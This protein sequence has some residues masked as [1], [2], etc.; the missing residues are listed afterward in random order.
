MLKISV[1]YCGLEGPDAAV[2]GDRTFKA[3]DPQAPPRSLAEC[4]PAVV[5]S[6]TRKCNLNCE[7]CHRDTGLPPGHGELE[8]DQAKAVLDDLAAF[9]VPIVEFCGGEPM[10]RH[11]LFELLQYANQLGLKTILSTNGTLI[12]S[13][14]AAGFDQSNVSRVGVSLVS[15]DPQVNDRMRGESGTFDR[16]IKG[17]R[18]CKAAGQYVGF[19][20][21]LWPELIEHLDAAFELIEAEQVDRACFYHPC[22]ADQEAVKQMPRRSQ[23]RD[24]VDRIIEFTGRAA[25]AGR[26]VEMVTEDGAFDGPYL[27]V[28]MRRENHPD[29]SQVRQM[30]EWDGGARFL[31]GVGVAHI[32][33]VGH[34]HPDRHATYRSLGSVKR[35]KFSEIWQDQTNPDLAG[36]R[37]RLPRLTGRCARCRFGNMCGGGLRARAQQ[38]TGCS[39]A[40]DPACYLTEGEILPTTERQV[41]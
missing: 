16:A 30:L 7:Q 15:A 39:W 9:G 23:V 40:S 37:D 1:L 27:Y 20:F 2:R 28:K 10:L 6:L 33:W 8:T 11:D 34:V 12:D 25:Q 24:V 36:L 35:R 31:S 29:A 18:L 38:L 21:T 5:W 41:V 13:D 22:P 3:F 26:S 32:D 17:V 4:K 14:A 19:R